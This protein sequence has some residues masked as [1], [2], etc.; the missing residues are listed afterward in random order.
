MKFDAFDEQI[1][2]GFTHHFRCATCPQIARASWPQAHLSHTAIARRLASLVRVGLLHT[3][4]SL[5]HP[6]QT[7][8][9]PIFAWSPL[10]EAPQSGM[11]AERLQR[12]WNGTYRLTAI[13]AP[14]RRAGDHYGGFGGR[15]KNSFQVT[16][17]LH[18]TALYFK[19]LGTDPERA[20]AWTSEDKLA[21]ERKHQKLPD[22][23]LRF[24]DGRPPLV[25]E[26]GGAYKALRVKE[27]HEDCARRG[28]SYELW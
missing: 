4:R 21:P 12:R 18:V 25:I 17:D 7:L 15:L 26:F 19:W 10:D 28:L 16:H 14:T 24:K 22:A 27:F 3:F 9:A 1:L 8:K 23:L 13:Y 5:V 2:V 11:I 20:A 6:E